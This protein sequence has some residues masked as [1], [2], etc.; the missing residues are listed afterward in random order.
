MGK[1]DTAMQSYLSDK[2]RFA[3]LF[4]RIFFQGRAVIHSRDLQ[5]SS[6]R[7]SDTKGQG[8]NRFRDIKMTLKSGEAFRILAVEN[9]SS[10]DYAMPYRCMQ[11]D[12][13]E[14]GKQLKELKAFNRS[15]RLLQTPA[16][17]LCGISKSDRLTPVYTLCLYHGEAPWEGPVSL[18]NMMDFG[19]DGDGMSRYFADY[20]LRLFC[21]NEAERFDMFH[22]ELQEL[23]SAMRY[24]RDKR[25]LRKLFEENETYRHLTAETT[26]AMSI[27]L[28]IPTLWEKREHY[29]NR[30]EKG[31]KYDM[32]QAIREWREDDKAE[33]RAEG[34][35]EK[36]TKVVQNMLKK[37]Y[38]DDEICELA[39]CT[40]EF[41]NQL[42]ET[43]IS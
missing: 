41:I 12:S 13:L 6:E 23:F 14:Y 36:T 21:V 11:Y 17:R 25:G 27:L 29:M 28:K 39:E 5:D 9:Q 37:G 24:R 32:C 15:Q 18:G 38:S 2:E 30:T 40:L 16:E 10:I 33:G 20:P 4:N 31:E 3:N 8:T 7:Y 42:R 19:N 22:T 1:P 35:L 43:A 34:T 26:E